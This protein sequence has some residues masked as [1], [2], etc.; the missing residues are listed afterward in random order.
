M[1]K[2]RYFINEAAQNLGISAAALDTVLA[3]SC[4]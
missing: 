4:Y 3:F 2:T 1:E